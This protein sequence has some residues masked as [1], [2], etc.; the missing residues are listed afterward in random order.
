[1]TF[2][3]HYK[4][5]CIPVL[6]EQFSYKNVMQ[7][8]RLD[9]IVVS[10][11]RHE[12]VA[13]VK[14]LDRVSDELSIITGQK[15]SIRRARKSIATFKLREGMPIGCMVTLRHRRMYEFYSRLVN[16]AMPRTRDFRGVSPRGFDGHGNYTLGIQEQIIFFRKSPMTGSIRSV[17]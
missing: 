9:K 14:V 4:K 11:C 8:P 13:D 1:M 7:V 12:A 10:S 2:M 15:P 3:E 6:R 5:E 16:V 17:G